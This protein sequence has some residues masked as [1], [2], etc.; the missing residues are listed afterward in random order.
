MP[1][2]N[3]WLKG[4]AKRFVIEKKIF[5]NFVVSNKPCDTSAFIDHVVDKTGSNEEG[6][7][8][9][10]IQPQKGEKMTTAKT[11]PY[12]WINTSAQKL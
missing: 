5:S 6:G 12:L 3:K 8:L 2:Q 9:H 10:Q 4:R 1:N 7:N 11:R